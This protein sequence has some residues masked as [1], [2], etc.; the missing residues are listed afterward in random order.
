MRLLLMEAWS[1]TAADDLGS[2]ML[3]VHNAGENGGIHFDAAQA[4]VA[5]LMAPS[6]VPELLEF[7]A[8][9][10]GHRAIF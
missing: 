7:K 8:D 2:C 1:A 6:L 4:F 9:E 3:K 5:R 10:A